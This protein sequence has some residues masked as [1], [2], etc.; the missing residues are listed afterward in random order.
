MPQRQMTS[1]NPNTAPNSHEAA[2]KGSCQL[3][4]DNN[5][6]LINW[7]KIEENYKACFGY[8]KKTHV[9]QPP[10]SKVNGFQLMANELKKKT[11]G[12]LELN[13]KQILE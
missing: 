5:L 7:L 1:G 2:P 13:S 8:E 9:G 4:K 6:I 11:R 12:R 10:S 3:N